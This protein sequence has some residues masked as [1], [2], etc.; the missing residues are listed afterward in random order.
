MG[1]TNGKVTGAGTI[2]SSGGNLTITGA[3][4]NDNANVTGLIVGAG[5]TLALTSNNGI[6]VATGSLKDP[7]LT[8]T[9]VSG[10]TDTFQAVAIY[11]GQLYIGAIS[12]FAQND[13]IDVKEFGSGDKVTWNGGTS[14]TVT[15]TSAGGGNSQT[16]TFSSAAIA[17]Q[18]AIGSST[19]GLSGGAIKTTTVGGVTVDQ[20]SYCFMP[21]TLIRTPEGEAL[22]ETVQRGDLVLT[23]DGEAKPVV[24]VGRQTIVSRFADPIRNLPIRIAAGALADNV[25]SR[26]LLVSP[27]HALL[28]EGVLVHAGALVNGTSVRR[29]SQVPESFVYYHVELEDHSLILA[30][31]VPAETFV[32]NV[33]RLHFDNWAE[34]ETLYPEGRAVAELPLPRAKAARQVSLF[35]SSPRSPSAPSPSA[36]LKRLKVELDTVSCGRVHPAAFSSADCLPVAG[37]QSLRHTKSELRVKFHTEPMITPARAEIQTTG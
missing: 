16:Y 30:E 17:Q 25:P 18:V 24:W 20:L 29:E 27:E 22:I 11:Q 23:A 33:D 34:H 19:T 10:Q 5:T 21:G 35:R 3:V 9:N 26:D 31:N 6:G 8:F 14:K 36:C 37:P 7:T 12:N 2:T 4:G 28:V 13:Y 1:G 15:I 32:D